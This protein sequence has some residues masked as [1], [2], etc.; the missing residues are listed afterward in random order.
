MSGR[1]QESGARAEAA[2]RDHLEAR[3]YHVRQV[4]FRCRS[5]EIDIVA[6]HDGQVVFVEVRSHESGD[7]GLPRESIG[8][9]KQRRLSRAAMTYL[10]QK[11][12]GEVSSRFDVVEVFL[13]ADGNPR[14][15]NVIPNAFEPRG[16]A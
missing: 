15:I 12:L 1:R 8:P 14:S 2:A 3:G 11:R 5:G 10:K 13:D 6:E 9:R 16:I 4:N 7:F